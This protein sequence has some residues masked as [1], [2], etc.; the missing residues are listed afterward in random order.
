MTRAPRLSVEVRLQIQELYARYNLLSDAA[1]AAGYADCFTAS[2]AMLSPGVG[3]EVRGRA[4]LI[5][6]K[7]RDKASRNGRYRRHWNANLCLEPLDDGTVRGRCY[8]L[9]YNGMPGSLPAIADCGVYEDILVRDGADWKFAS[10]SLTMDGS[11]WNQPQPA[12]A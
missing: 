6:H 8:L 5:A 1:D 4:A 9:A 10:R 11:T 12:G 7:E 3:I 2:G